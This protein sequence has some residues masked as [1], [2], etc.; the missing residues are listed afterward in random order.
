MAG[1]FNPVKSVGFTALTDT[2]PDWCLLSLLPCSLRFPSR[3]ED[4]IWQEVYEEPSIMR[5]FSR[6]CKLKALCA[7]TALE[8][9][10]HR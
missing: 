4:L 1:F 7:C 8:A 3:P 6:D 10:C 2:D 9:L 5:S